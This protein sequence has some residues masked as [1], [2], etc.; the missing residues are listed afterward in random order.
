MASGEGK[1]KES[2]PS[3]VVHRSDGMAR[4]EITDLGML[5][6]PDDPAAQR[7]LIRRPRDG[8]RLGMVGRL[9]PS[10]HAI[11]LDVTYRD[12]AYRVTA[13]KVEAEH[14]DELTSGDLGL[15]VKEA[16]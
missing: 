11:T 9:A 5:G 15:P 6:T 8:D 10:R 1:V 16:A 4:Q 13:V 14:G 7:L 3:V 12:G 2:N